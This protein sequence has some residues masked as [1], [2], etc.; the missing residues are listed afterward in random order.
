MATPSL[1]DPNFARTVVLLIEHHPDGAVGLVLNRPSE[2]PIAEAVPA[3][4]DLGADP[5]VVYIGGPVQPGAALGL[6]RVHGSEAALAAC[7]G[8]VA[9]WPGLG[10]VD[11]EIAPDLV[12]PSVGG[13]RL[14]AGYAGW[15]PLQLEREL[16]TD[17]WFVLEREPDDVWTSEPGDLWTRV[18]RRQGGRIAQFAHCPV[19]PATN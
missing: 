14:F 7:R 13:L 12:V 3:W 8:I 16:A 19:D 18:L 15:G 1:L 5:A 11:L 9:L 6:G 10:I 4:R 17:S 2:I